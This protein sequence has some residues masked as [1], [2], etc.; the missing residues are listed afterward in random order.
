MI[1]ES[2]QTEGDS[3]TKLYMLQKFERVLHNIVSKQVLYFSYMQSHFFL[4]SLARDLFTGTVYHKSNHKLK[5]IESKIMYSC[6]EN[7][8]GGIKAF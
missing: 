5:I 2:L 8:F 6:K 1:V 4:I 7:S 3:L